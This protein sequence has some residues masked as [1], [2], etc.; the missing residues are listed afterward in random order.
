MEVVYDI[1]HLEFWK[2]DHYEVSYDHLKLAVMTPLLK[3]PPPENLVFYSTSFGSCQRIAVSSF[4][5][6]LCCFMTIN[7]ALKSHIYSSHLAICCS[8][9]KFKDGL[10]KCPHQVV[11]LKRM[12][13]IF[14]LCLN[15]GNKFVLFICYLYLIPLSL[16]LKKEVRVSEI[17]CKTF[18]GKLF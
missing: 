12:K 11:C 7:Y 15:W 4:P 18:L 17:K 13:N 5:K 3:L 1:S 2:S 9:H 6:E 14:W 10:I 16:K 8:T